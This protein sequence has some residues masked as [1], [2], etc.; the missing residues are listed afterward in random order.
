M[1]GEGSRTL[2]PIAPS[3]VSVNPLPMPPAAATPTGDSGS[4]M[5]VVGSRMACFRTLQPFDSHA[6]LDRTAVLPG[7]ARSAAAGSGNGVCR[8]PLDGNAHG[9]TV[10]S[11]RRVEP[12]RATA[13]RAAPPGSGARDMS[14]RIVALAAMRPRLAETLLAFARPE[15]PAPPPSRERSGT[16]G[17]RQG[18]EFHLRQTK[19]PHGTSGKPGTCSCRLRVRSPRFRRH[20][21]HHA[22]PCGMRT[23]PVDLKPTFTELPVSSGCDTSSC[24][25]NIDPNEVSSVYSIRT[26]T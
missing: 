5:L 9:E 16:T 19:G 6:L 23:G 12:S 4:S 1:W 2:Y 7:I 18:G 17:R 8:E 13:N 25:A 11:G 24:T 14:R 22:H 20:A 26:P 21:R 10:P 15:V 3:R